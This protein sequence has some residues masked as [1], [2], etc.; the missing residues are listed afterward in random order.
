MTIVDLDLIEIEIDLF[1]LTPAF[2][3][4]ST[5]QGTPINE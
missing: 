3:M 4:Q 5:E 1:I 2:L